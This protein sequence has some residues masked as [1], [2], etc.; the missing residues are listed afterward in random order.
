MWYTL[1]FVL[2]QTMP[3]PPPGAGVAFGSSLGGVRLAR[4]ALTGVG[5]AAGAGEAA[6]LGVGVAAAF[7]W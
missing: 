2:T 3:G 4:A 6:S 1:L 5:L 7:L